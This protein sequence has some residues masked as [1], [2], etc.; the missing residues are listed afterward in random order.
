M[1]SVSFLEFMFTAEKNLAKTNESVELIMKSE[2]FKTIRRICFT[3]YF[4]FF[5]MF[6]DDIF[7]MMSGYEILYNRW[8]RLFASLLLALLTAKPYWYI[9][10]RALLYYSNKRNNI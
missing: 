4:M 3:L 9:V 8:F 5:S 10:Y 2:R 7:S 6:K 1:K